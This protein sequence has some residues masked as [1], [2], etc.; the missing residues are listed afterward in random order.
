M[1]SW[2]SGGSA[3]SPSGHTISSEVS[4]VRKK[5]LVERGDA[6]DVSI[7]RE[8]LAGSSSESLSGTPVPEVP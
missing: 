4:W 5:K 3:S 1:R 7:G 8:S 6:K 2:A